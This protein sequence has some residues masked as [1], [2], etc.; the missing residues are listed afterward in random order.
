M[1]TRKTPPAKAR[2]T[3]APKLSPNPSAPGDPSSAA[4]GS[5]VCDLQRT[6]NVLEKHVSDMNYPGTDEFNAQTF[7]RHPFDDNAH[8]VLHDLAVRVQQLSDDLY[9]A[10]QERRSYAAL[11]P[12]Q[13]MARTEELEQE[14]KD[15]QADQ[16][17]QEEWQQGTQARERAWALLPPELTAPGRYD[18]S[19][20][21]CGTCGGR[22]ET[23]N[24]IHRC[25]AC[26]RRDQGGR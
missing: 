18:H 5:L 14:T 6:I 10:E 7:P 13:Q 12:Q 22:I 8:Q 21:R 4:I 1:S 24:G 11:T 19:G 9:S 26:F 16:V 17:K 3:P 25:W 20:G 23:I 2:S 15:A